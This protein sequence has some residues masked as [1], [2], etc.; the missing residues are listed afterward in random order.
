MFLRRSRS[1]DGRTQ[2]EDEELIPLIQELGRFERANRATR[3][4]EQMAEHPRPP[5]DGNEARLGQLP[6]EGV[7][8]QMPVRTSLRDIQRPVIGTSPSCIRLSPAACN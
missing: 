4:R 6:G 5:H 1:A 8:N 2:Q 7:A 3:R